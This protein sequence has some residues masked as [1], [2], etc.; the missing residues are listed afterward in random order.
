MLGVQRNFN[1]SG[2]K[3]NVLGYSDQRFTTSTGNQKLAMAV[4]SALPEGSILF[5]RRMTAIAKR[6]GGTYELTFTNGD[7]TEKV[8]ADRVV[9]AL[10]FIVLRGL[11]Y[12]SAGF[13]AAKINAIENL[14][15]GYHTKLH[16]QFAGRP[17]NGPGPWPHPVTGQIWTDL[18]FQCS[19]D[20][21]LGQKGHAGLVERFTG[22]APAMVDTPPVPY[23]SIADSDVV[24][25]EAKR[26]L[27]MLD[28]IWPGCGKQWNGK[29]TFG[30]AQADP[31]TLASYSSWL[32]GQ[33]TTIAGH[34]FERQGNCHFAGEHTSV[35]AQG[36]MEGGAE[37]GMRAADAI[38]ADY[39]IKN[40][41][42]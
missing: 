29:A 33:C 16:L 12:S 13:D 36:F 2:G 17:W 24:K 15:Y 18:Q 40:A 41:A 11:D 35:E 26:F 22:A 19:T 23:A 5:G 31:N 27:A 34:E 21:S 30:N 9:L 38:L 42:H 39:R 37:T 20:Y 7:A 4:A 10:P 3:I 32:V 14:G 25:R 1:A 8:S 6:P 28:E